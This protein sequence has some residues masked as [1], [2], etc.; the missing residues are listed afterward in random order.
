MY[1]CYTIRSK[2]KRKQNHYREKSKTTSQG[3]ILFSLQQPLIESHGFVLSSQ[4]ENVF[5][6][7]AQQLELSTHSRK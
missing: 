6:R 7:N 5:R 1:I 3:T 2:L 4:T